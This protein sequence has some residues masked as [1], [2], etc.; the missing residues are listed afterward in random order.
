MRRSTTPN[1]EG[2]PAPPVSIAHHSGYGRTTVLAE[3]VRSDSDEGPEAVHEADIATAEACPPA[4]PP[5]RLGP[6]P[7]R[8]RGAEPYVSVVSRVRPDRS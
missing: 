8:A 4:R 3:A 6:A 2:T 1:Q 5:A 7:S